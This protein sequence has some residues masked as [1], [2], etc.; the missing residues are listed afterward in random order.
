M[1]ITDY[2]E[3]DGV[4]LAQLVRKGEVT[5]AELVE[6]A[7]TRIERRNG[8][9]NAVVFKAYD[10]ARKTAKGTLPD[11]PFRGVPFLIKDLGVAVAGWPQSRGSKFSAGLVD[12]AD[13]GL[14]ARYRGS[15]AVFVGKTNTPEYGITG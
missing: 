10:E 11:G 8:A 6:E 3:H 4:A 9:L 1:A 14:I 5:P 13:S 7:I 2:A 12:E 15:G